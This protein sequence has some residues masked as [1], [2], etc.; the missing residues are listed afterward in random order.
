MWRKPKMALIL[1]VALLAA[2]TLLGAHRLSAQS[3]LPVADDPLVRLPGTQPNQLTLEG[4]NRCMNCHGDYDQ[5][6]EPA[7]NW[8]GSM[9]AQAAR[10]PLFW[11]CM[12]VAGQDSS[13]AIGRPNAVDICE[14][15]HFPKG[16]LEGRSDPVNVSLMTGADYDGVQCDFCHQLYD[17]FFEG[18]HENAREGDL[19][20]DGAISADEWRAYWDETNA[21]STPSQPVAATTYAED[22]GFA[23]AL[24]F[25]NGDPFY[26]NNLPVSPAYV[27]NGAGEY[28]VST[29]SKGEKRASFADATGRHDMLY[30]RYHKSRYFCHT[31][32]DVS[33]PVLA[34]LGQD[35]TQPLT[36][37]T[38][39]AYSYYHVER[40]SS[41]FMLSDYAQEG[42][43][44]GIGP[45][46]PGQF[47]T[48]YP[49]NYIAKCQD[50]HMPDRVGK[51]A[52][53]KDAPVRPTE[54]AEH[55]NSG[56]PQHDL[57]GGNAW[58]SYILASSVPGSPQHDPVNEQ[59]MYQGPGVLTLDMTQG[60]SLD[61]AAILAGVDRARQQLLLA[62]AIEELSYEAAEGSLSFRIQN[63]TGHKL[64]SGFPEGR[65]MFV[66]VKAYAGGALIYEVNP[67]DSTIGTLKG[68]PD[69]YSANSPPLGPN[70]AYVDELVY[71][72]HPSSALTG[73]DETFHFALATGRYKDNR[74][75]PKG[76]RIDDAPERISQPVWH[77]ADAPGYFSEEEYAGGYDEVELHDYGIYLT[78]ADSIQVSLYYQTTSREYVEFLRD[79]IKGTATTLP[80]DAYIVQTDPFYAQLRAWGDT[81]W[82]L[83]EHNKDLPGAAPIQMAQATIG[84]VPA[85]EV[86]LTA[87]EQT[88]PEDV[89]TVTVE[90]A[91][92][93]TAG[94][95]VTVPYTTG[96]TAT[97]GGVDH[98]LSDG[99]IEIGP[100]D[101]IASLKFQVVNDDLYERDETVVITLGEPDHAVLGT[102]A[103]QTITILDNDDPP[104]IAFSSATYSVAEAAGS[105]SITVTLSGATALTAT[106]QYATGGGT[107]TPDED[108]TP[109]SGSLTFTPG[110]T[111]QA[112]SV[113]I[114]PDGIHE[115]DETVG[116][117]LQGPVSATLGLDSATL[118]ILD[119]DPMPALSIDDVTAS[120]SEPSMTFRVT[121]SAVS[122][123][124]AEVDFETNDGTAIAGVD[125]VAASGTL[126]IPA[127]TTEGQIVVDLIDNLVDESTR[128][129]TVDLSKPV[130]ASLDKAQGVGTI[131][132]NDGAPEIAFSSATYSVSEAQESAS[133][134][135][136]LTGATALTAT[137]QYATGGGTATPG[138]DYTPAS[139]SLT[140]TPGLTSQSFAIPILPDGI[141]E[142]DETVG[143]SLQG[144]VSATLGLDSATLTILDDDDPPEIAFSSAAYSVS[145]AQ[146][147][148]SITVTLTGATALTATVQY[149]TGGGTA[150][151]D[152]D[153][154][155]VSGRLTFTPGVT[156]QVFSVPIL[157]NDLHD[158]D[159]TVGLSMSNEWNASLGTANATLT[160][161]DDDEAKFEI[162]LPL[163]IRNWP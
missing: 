22:S 27:E 142:G 99:Y 101:T 70:E 58:I 90:V 126:T 103:V 68:L 80:P 47:D 77:G 30:S 112:F 118:T 63:Q 135:V 24:T 62:A 15:C 87:A 141:Y 159:R 41:E 116:L 48:S 156:S 113:P 18:T 44:P 74:I 57:T 150:T 155:P 96:G 124:A 92:N 148:A 86:S 161:V 81:I 21:S 26:A 153:Y 115:G 110:V 32:H 34:N 152:E 64:I 120:E 59:L 4:P 76:F 60:D 73:E 97:G 7:F 6:V 51:G 37:E 105:A 122:G 121:L 79:E 72:V 144:P 151:P 160:I 43:A 137:V 131:L 158:G 46:A 16:W 11:A 123:L 10:D 149:A 146:E 143:L 23:A 49:S 125:Y 40:T 14:R 111:S 53:M 145:E 163:V 136:S 33:N 54:S 91:L 93:H 104:A 109:V 89:G 45:F 95:T 88:V 98:N 1:V 139:G 50:C 132:D 67:Y 19:D 8:K 29:S 83:W 128:T 3:S 162:Y 13:W 31:C 138:E 75:P 12:V 154:T 36:T 56:Q 20:G 82:Q 117:S 5:A 140:F 102:P 65:R 100:T 2:C 52:G 9:M 157:P 147:S 17:P 130:H 127:G 61:P 55:P 25:F 106:V 107:A 119:D 66:N 133:I 71:E 69:T 78:E 39:P 42:G 38:D 35:G 114:L 129:F 28:Y 84:V 108:Y 134:T 85:P 94:V